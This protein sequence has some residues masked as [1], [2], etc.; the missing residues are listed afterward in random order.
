MAA[1]KGY[2]CLTGWP[3]KSQEVFNLGEIRGYEMPV[4][5]VDMMGLQ[6]VPCHIAGMGLGIVLLGDKIVFNSLMIARTC[7]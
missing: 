2:K 6:T 5:S 1:G 7:R 3:R 4:N